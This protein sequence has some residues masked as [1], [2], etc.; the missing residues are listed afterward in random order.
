MAGVPLLRAAQ[1]HS[2]YLSMGVTNFLHM[3]FVSHTIQVSCELSWLFREKQEMLLLITMSG[4][5][6]VHQ[7]VPH[8]FNRSSERE[9]RQI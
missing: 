1:S 7:R 9:K 2:P 6:L 3:K 8:I 4:N 5:R